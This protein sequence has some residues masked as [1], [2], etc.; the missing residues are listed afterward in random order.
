MKVFVFAINLL[1]QNASSYLSLS[2]NSIEFH[3]VDSAS[4]HGNFDTFLEKILV[5]NQIGCCIFI[6]RI[7][8]VWFQKK[9]LQPNHDGVETQNWFP[10]FS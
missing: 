3:P 7:R 10:I 8:W 1:H 6:E 2:H 9:V 5:S 4:G